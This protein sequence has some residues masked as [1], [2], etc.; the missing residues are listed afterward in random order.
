LSLRQWTKG[1][2]AV[3][4]LKKTAQREELL[5]PARPGLLEHWRAW[6]DVLSHERRL[7]DKTVSA[8]GRDV[9]GFLSFMTG[10]C[11]GPANVTDLADLPPSTFR[12]WLARRRNEGVGS[13]TLAREL[14][15]VR[16]F[17]LHL[18]KSDLVSSAG[19][20]AVKGPKL[21]Q[22]LPKPLA[23]A[24][25]L[26]VSDQSEQLHEEPWIAARDA[27]VLAL[28]YGSGLR[29]SEVLALTP[30]AFANQPTRSLRILGKGG[31]TRLSPVLPQVENIVREYLS[32]VPMVLKPDEPMFRGARGGALNPA[33]IQ[34]AM[35]TM[36][37][38]LGLPDSATPHA[39]R[40]SFA[41]HLLAGG[42]DLRTI[43]ELLGHASLS[44]T[45][46]YTQVDSEH[47]MQAWRSAHPR[48]R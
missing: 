40:H 44:T 17:F 22:S 8:Y 37:S 42:G 15:S 39:L 45:Q 18:E 47:L 34:K 21:P 41:T 10:Y 6:L 32:L 13:R 36:R 9:A 2:E 48:A 29:I 20:R 24:D 14:S 26:R 43:Q 12:A 7:A 33:I 38:A 35:R 46:I 28:C 3:L 1:L 19:V 4:P 30:S 5:V 23:P 16:S 11:G 27:A 31:K 25:A